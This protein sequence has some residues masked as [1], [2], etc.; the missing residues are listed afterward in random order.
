[1]NKHFQAKHAK[2]WNFHTIKTMVYCI[3][4]NQILHNDRNH[5]VLFLGGSNMSQTNPRLQMAAILKNQKLTKNWPTDRPISTKF[6][7]YALAR[8]NQPI[9][10][11]DFLNLRW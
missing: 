6:G 10:F 9:K 7:I 11:L 5:K 2:Y 3:D 4:S 8:T 1:M